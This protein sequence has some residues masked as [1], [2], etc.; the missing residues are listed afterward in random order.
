M[1][2]YFRRKQ[3]IAEREGQCVLRFVPTSPSPAAV[4]VA[5]DPAVPHAPA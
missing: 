1:S 4:N 2:T 5:V 3:A